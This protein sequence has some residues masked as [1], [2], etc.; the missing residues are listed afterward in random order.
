MNSKK[1]A[2][3]LA[4]ILSLAAICAP[5]ISA[6]ASDLDEVMPVSD[7]PNFQQVTP[8]LFRGGRP[9][10][11]GMDELS[12]RGVRMVINLQGGDLRSKWAP[13]VRLRE[14]GELPSAIA[15]EGAL[16]VKLGMKYFNFP[17]DS[18]DPVDATE[19][20]MIDAVLGLIHSAPDHPIYL[21]CQ[22]GRDRTGLVSALE[23][24][25]LEGWTPARAH[26]EWTALGHRA[27]SQFF[28]GHLDEYFFARVKSAGSHAARPSR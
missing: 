7:L 15:Q 6:R 5:A 19:G 11:A 20:Q 17:L 9:T 1:L 2:H 28:T 3:T 27:M 8:N 25:L 12:R 22:H 23:R 4:L 13:L 16:A 14:P 24:V 21:H 10:P 18:L 26:A